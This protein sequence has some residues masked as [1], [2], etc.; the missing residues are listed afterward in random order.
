MIRGI[1]TAGVA[2]NGKVNW[3]ATRA[4]GFRFAVLRATV[5]L[6]TDK[7]FMTYWPQLKKAGLIRGAY[8]YWRVADDPA[9]Q[10]E[11]FAHFV[12]PVLEAGDFTVFDLEFSTNKKDLKKRTGRASWGFTA[13]EARARAERTWCVLQ[14]C[15][16]SPM[17]YTSARIVDGPDL[18]GLP[19]MMASSPL[20]AVRRK[21]MVPKEWGGP[22]DWWISQDKL[23]I[24]AKTVPGFTKGDLDLDSFNPL[25]EGMAGKR[26]EWLQ[27]CLQLKVTG[28]FDQRTDA[29]V[30]NFQNNSRLPED[31][32]VGPATFGQILSV[33]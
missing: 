18:K 29:A 4:A 19:L 28:K 9:A 26:V 27:R 21:A 20:W 22:N 25:Y 2:G 23:D 13:K 10:A 6:K 30:R 1:D 16:A 12:K 14:Q 17:T 3:T 31:G 33:T 32:I 5:G 7:A 11:T 15:C 8:M 24:E